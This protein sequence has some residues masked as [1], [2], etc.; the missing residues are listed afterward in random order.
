[1]RRNPGK[2]R[3][4]TLLELL[5]ALSLLALLTALLTGGLHTAIVVWEKSTTRMDASDDFR[6]VR[7]WLA[8]QIR[9]ARPLRTPATPAGHSAFYGSRDQVSFI[10]ASPAHRGEGGLY[11]LTLQAQRSGAGTALV[12]DYTPIYPGSGTQKAVQDSKQRVLLEGLAGVRFSYFGRRH[13]DAPIKWHDTWH[14]IVFPPRLIRIS[15]RASGR[16]GAAWPPL[17]VAIRAGGGLRPAV[18]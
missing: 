18:E 12:L 8:R 5:I 9:Q 1:M 4:S 15:L 10:V 3:G 16:L 6:V 2:Q 14:G 11:R 7:E 13:Q 17:V